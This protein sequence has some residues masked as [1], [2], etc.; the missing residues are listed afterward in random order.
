MN[1]IINQKNIYKYGAFIIFSV[2][3]VNFNTCKK[4]DKVENKIEI[5]SPGILDLSGL[6]FDLIEPFPLAGQWDA[7]PGL[8][9]STPEEFLA[10][11]NQTPVSL[12]IPGY[13]VN[14]NLPANG[15]VTYRLKL[16]VTEPGNLMLYLREA[17]SAYKIFVWSKER[18]LN[19]L[20]SAGKLSKT[21]EDSIG[22]YS[23]TAKAFRV[24]PGSIIFFQVSNYLY[25]RGGAYYSPI[26]GGS[27]KT[28]IYLRDKERKKFFFVGVFFLLFLYHLLL[29][30]HRV[31]DKFTLFYSL[32]CLAWFVRILLFERVTRNWFEPS[33]FME[34]SQI[35]LE[36]LAF[37]TLQI[38]SLQFFYQFF[39]PYIKYKIKNIFLIPLLVIFALTLVT[40]YSFYTNFLQVTQVYMMVLLLYSYYAVFKYLQSKDTRYSGTVFL[41]GT[42]AI[43]FTTIF[44][45]IIFLKRL[46]LPFLTDFG[47]TFYSI[48]L[49]VV[50]SS[51]NSHAWETAEYL[52]LNLRNE[53]DWK[54]IE[55]RKEKEKAEKA[56]ELKDKFISIVSHDIRSPLFGISSVM[57]L[58]TETPP[59]MTPDRA[60]K[61]LNDAAVG[62]KNLLS[63]VED[64]IQYSRFQ[65]ATI[66]P[67]YQLFDFYQ[68]LDSLYEKAKPIIDVKNIKFEMNVQES[69]IGIGDPHLIQHLIWNLLTNAFKFTSPKGVVN[70]TVLEKENRW[71]VI[72]TDNGIGFPDTWA[73]NLLNEG[74][75]Y[76]RKGTA[77]EIGAGVGL[78]FCKEVCERHGGEILAESKEGEGSK[79]TFILPN[80]DKVVMV[81]DDNPGYR[82][83]LRKILRK[84][85]VV[86]WEEEFADHALRSITK[87]KPDLIIVDFSMPDK[88][89]LTFL[90]ELYANPDMS[91][92]KSIMLSSSQTDPRTGKKLELD[93]LQ[94][95][96][97]AFF[98][99][100]ISEERLLVEIQKL[101]KLN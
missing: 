10:L 77:D 61:V 72:V 67:D 59:S 14:Q 50:I 6:N 39:S 96:G 56:S 54:T 24:F 9:P 38:F 63:M 94:A 22:Y 35:R 8:L 91:E 47:F 17:S 21:K 57:N 76:L 18:G 13:W 52:T 23:Q 83:Q 53:V 93:L 36:Y 78:A 74:F 86:I 31:K 92:I 48:C 7:F 45:S 40:P 46:D 30:I 70:V 69:S 97:D 41:I 81:L 27:E 95:G 55:L 12:K 85:P 4:T 101:L 100:S 99:K 26:L 11:D 65:N 90:H 42:S 68:L 84:V 49:A 2:C 73:T 37:I 1:R 87:L 60:Q 3:L 82:S 75:Q 32:M 16:K 28:L 43:L 5:S 80:Y 51:R 89:G 62:L 64:L 20:G 29:F 33:D 34:M 88:D 19:E 58:L 44:D 25:S 15:Y 71:Q 79:F 66:F 98:R